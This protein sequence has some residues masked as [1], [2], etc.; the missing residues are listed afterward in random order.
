M[1]SFKVLFIA[2][3]FAYSSTILAES[4]GDDAFDKE[5]LDNSVAM[6]LYAASKGKIA[7]IVRQY[8]YG[9]KIDMVKVVS[10]V[11]AAKACGPTPAAMTYEDSQGE[12]NTLRYMVYGDCKAHGG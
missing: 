4:S 7:P 12:L 2:A 11:K 6:D 3:I 9:M 8:N 1:K 10:V 5:M